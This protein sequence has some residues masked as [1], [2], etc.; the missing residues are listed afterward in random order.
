[1]RTSIRLNLRSSL[2]F[3]LIEILVAVAVLSLTLV[4]FL[5][6]SRGVFD[7]YRSGRANLDNYA[8]GRALLDAIAR[9]VQGAI[10]RGD[11][12]SF[13]ASGGGPRELSFYTGV[14]GI[15][16]G[17]ATGLRDLSY[18]RYELAPA[19]FS[20]K[21]SDAA[22]TWDDKSAIRIG[23]AQTPP[24]ATSRTL[25]A[26]VLAFDYRFL[27]QDGTITRTPDD[28]T[29]VAAVRF[30]IAVADPNSL[31]ILKETGLASSLHGRLEQ[32]VSD[33]HL[34]SAKSAWEALLKDGIAMAGFP[35]PALS[36]V[37]VFERFA[38]VK[39]FFKG[40]D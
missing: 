18:V 3:T 17:G 29:K 16:S 37:N 13:P 35:G 7:A 12:P 23:S 33:D 39:T 24:A 1:M 38:S 11:L 36:G 19:E 14:A 34:V 15:P 2:G 27:L 20:L 30:S 40:N 25:S 26:G 9:D 4:L 21:R 8:T 10:I 31:R 22:I 32:E 6:F 5:Q 28:V